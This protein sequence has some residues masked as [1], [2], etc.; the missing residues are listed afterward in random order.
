MAHI[1]AD[2]VELAITVTISEQSDLCSLR[3]DLLNVDPELM[4]R[5]S[6]LPPVD[7]ILDH[8]VVEVGLV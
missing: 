8:L 4:L 6:L 1:H 7:R 2:L 3:R 5:S